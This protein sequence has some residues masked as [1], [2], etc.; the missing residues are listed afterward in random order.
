MKSGADALESGTDALESE[1]EPLESE[2]EPLV[3]GT[4]PLVSETEPLEFLAG[5]LALAGEIDAAPADPVVSRGKAGFSISG[6]FFVFPISR[7]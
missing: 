6:G 2:A 1:A 5:A 3:S 4:E 7:S